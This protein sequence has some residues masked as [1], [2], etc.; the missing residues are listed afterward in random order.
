M[1]LFAQFKRTGGRY[2]DA[3]AANEKLI[4]EKRAQLIKRMTHGGLCKAKPLARRCDTAF[5]ANDVK[6][7]Q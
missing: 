1:N 4:I 3:A 7:A 2:H 6:H 5:F